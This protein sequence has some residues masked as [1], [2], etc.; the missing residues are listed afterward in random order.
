MNQLGMMG[1]NRGTKKQRRNQS[2]AHGEDQLSRL[3]FR[4]KGIE[5]QRL[6]LHAAC[7]HRRT[8]DEEQIADDRP[9]ERG[10]NDVGQ[11]RANG[12]DGDDQL[13]EIAERRVEQRADGRPHPVRELL[14]A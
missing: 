14:G 10:A 8:A 4:R 5:P 6:A 2:C 12:E 1:A 11:P 3:R 7:H 13:G 9:T